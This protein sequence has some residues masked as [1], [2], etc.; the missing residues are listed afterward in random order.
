MNY[1]RRH[2][3]YDR[4]NHRR[5][6]DRYLV[7]S[8]TLEYPFLLISRQGFGNRTSRFPA[9]YDMYQG[10]ATRATG[11]ISVNTEYI[12]VYR[13]YLRGFQA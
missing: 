8:R 3:C 2:Y 4:R 6:M 11:H 1:L 7:V 13:T 9:L 10:G 12:M 5:P